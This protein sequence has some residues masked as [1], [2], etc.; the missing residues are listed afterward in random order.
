MYKS[1]SMELAGRTLTVDVGRVAAQANGAAFMHYGD[2]VVLSTATASEEPREGIDFFP[3][4]VEYEEK[5]YSVGK[6]PGG[7][8]RREGKASE[9]AILTSRVI[10]RPMRPLFP[11][12]YRNDVT[13][14]NMVMSVDPECSPELTAMLGSAIAVA[15]SDIPF[16]GPTASTQVGMIDGEFIFNPTS[17]Q[18]KVSDLAL[19]V[20]STK[21]K[22]IMIEAGA[23]EI[24]EAKMIEAIFAA[25]QVNQTIIA[26]I[27]KIVA[28][29]GKPKHSYESCDVPADLWEDM[30]SVISSD[31]META[32]FTD[33]KQKKRSQYS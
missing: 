4:S 14:N 19:T 7:F 3:L 13:L 28:E 24:P 22:V 32:V 31:E 1:F 15:I 2:T 17:E 23:N 11:K 26:F 33:E 20:A 16:D 8:N 21:E 18:K 25:H 30:T 27:E 5:L 29:C 12:D 9:N 10:D 6:I